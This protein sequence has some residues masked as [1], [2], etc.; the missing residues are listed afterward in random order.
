MTT[1][2][3]EPRP[4]RKIPTREPKEQTDRRQA[5]NEEADPSY[6]GH[7]A[8]LHPEH[9]PYVSTD[10]SH[11]RAGKRNPSTHTPVTFDAEGEYDLEEDERYYNTQL[12]TS[13][14]RYQV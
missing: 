5:M 2:Y 6:T 7:D 3:R 13:A 14:R 10:L 11:S 4:V 8:G 1:Y 9:R 12:P